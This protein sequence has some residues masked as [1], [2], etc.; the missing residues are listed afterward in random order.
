MFV[1][2]SCPAQADGTLKIDFEKVS[3]SSPILR[4]KIAQ[5]FLQNKESLPSTSPELLDKKYLKRMDSPIPSPR[6]TTGVEIIARLSLSIQDQNQRV[7]PE[8]PHSIVLF[9]TPDLF[10]TPKFITFLKP[11]QP[12]STNEKG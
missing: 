7:R 11:T 6:L 3:R 5:S 12:D 8:N 4:D 9:N 2:R 1:D 10:N